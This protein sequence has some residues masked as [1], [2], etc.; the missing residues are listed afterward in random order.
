[1]TTATTLRKFLQA[2][3][4]ECETVPHPHTATTLDSAI[5]ARINSDC[6]AKAVMLGDDDGQM[7]MAVLPASHQLKLKQVRKATGRHLH[8]VREMDFAQLFPDCEVGAIPALGNA[9]GMDMVW[10]DCLADQS[11]IFLEAGD[12]ESLVHVT[13]RDFI[14]LVRDCRHGSI[15]VHR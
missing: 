15:S 14:D 2:H 13:G 4:V 1:M 5:A 6:M 3:H 12:H 9:Y 7:V 8:L 11:D 10:D